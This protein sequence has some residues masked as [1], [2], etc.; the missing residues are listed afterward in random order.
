MPEFLCGVGPQPAGLVL[1]GEPG[2][3]KTTLWAHTTHLAAESGFRV[4]TTRESVA[5]AKLTFAALADLLSDVEVAVIER[6]APVQQVALNRVLLRGDKAPAPMN[7]WR[8]PRSCQ[9]SNY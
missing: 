7:E 4:L 6:L 5:E 8:P 9:S 1:K 3:G 2:I